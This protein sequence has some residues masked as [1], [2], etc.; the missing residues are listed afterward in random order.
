MFSNETKKKNTPMPSRGGGIAGGGG[1]VDGGNDPKS[2]ITGGGRELRPIR[3]ALI[4]EKEEGG[5][6]FEKGGGG[7][8]KKKKTKGK[9]AHL[10]GVFLRGAENKTPSSKKGVG[11]VGFW[12]AKGLA[13]VFLKRKKGEK[14]LSR[15]MTRGEDSA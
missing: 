12:K 3:R 6:G 14:R 7:G 10:R 9:N 13:P 11:K 4:G 2:I 5:H 1:S 8:Q 15:P